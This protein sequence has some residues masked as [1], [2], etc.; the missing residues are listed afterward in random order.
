MSISKLFQP[1]D[2]GSLHL[3]H[4]VVFAP[5]TRYRSD[6]AHVPLPHVVEYYRQRASVPGTLMITEAIL[7]APRAA[8][9]NNAPGIWSDDQIAAWKKVSDPKRP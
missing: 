4:R 3:Q 1:F 7:I 5:S 2:L 6:D 9:M 8:G